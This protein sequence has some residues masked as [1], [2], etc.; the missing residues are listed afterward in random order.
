MGD[1]SEDD[2]KANWLDRMSKC[3][4]DA[5]PAAPS[6]DDAIAKLVECFDTKY[7]AN[8]TAGCSE[9]FAEVCDV[10]VNGGEVA[11]CKNR[12]EVAAFLDTL[13]NT[14]GATNFKITPTGQ[15]LGDDGMGS[16]DTWTTDWGDGGCTSTWECQDG[17]WVIVKDIIVAAPHAAPAAEEAAPAAEE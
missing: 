5:K 3:I 15:G 8:D 17:N 9:V 12:A 1:M 16:T 11:S 4:E 7:N 6:M 13:R 10:T 14:F 2:F